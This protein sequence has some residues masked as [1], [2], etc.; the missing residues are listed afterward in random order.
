MCFLPLPGETHLPIHVNGDFISRSDRHSIWFDSSKESSASD[1][2]TY[3][4]KLLL[5]AIG[6]SYAHFVVNYTRKITMAHSKSALLSLL[7]KFYNLF[8]I[9]SISD[10]D[11]WLYSKAFL[12]CMC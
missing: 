5:E 9:L 10:T 1:Q 7:D 4:N 3:W 12:Y 11:P 8:P 6:A 2:K